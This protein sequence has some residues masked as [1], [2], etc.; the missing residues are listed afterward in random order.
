VAGM[1]DRIVVMYAGRV[2]EEAVPTTLFETPGHPYT[3]GLINSLPRLTGPRD[4]L[5]PIPG[6]PP[7]LSHLP[8][9]CPF[10]PRCASSDGAKCT[11]ERPGLDVVGSAQ[12]AA[13]WHPLTRPRSVG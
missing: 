4:A 12:Q 2:V 6:L 11:T 13:C 3:R 8:P 5:T 1:A 9:G 10:N 7:D